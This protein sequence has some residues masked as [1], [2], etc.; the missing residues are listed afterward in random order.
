MSTPIADTSARAAGWAGAGAPGIEAPQAEGL[1]ERKKRLMRQQLSDTATRMFL[2]RGFDAVR[3]SEIAEACGVSEKTV[4]NYFPTKEALILDRLDATVAALRTG[5]ADPG[6]SPVEAALR[7]LD[8]EL[9][10]MTSWLAAQDDPVRAGASIRRF[11]AL[12]Q[13]APSLRA[14]QS[15][16]MDQFV[17][18]AAAALAGRAAM[19]PDDPEPRIAA[20]ALLGL[21]RVQFQAL[22]KYLD[23][24]RTPAQLHRAVSADVRR[25]ARLID[26]GLS[27]SAF[28]AG[29]GGQ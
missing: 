24:T 15:D 9:G 25:A 16:M 4:F 13:A 23:G 19:S 8:A 20:T 1:R 29:T 10:A 27:S 5:L 3:V 18:V 2:E 28:T 14:H 11:G 22:G 21:W 7:I 17:A 26:T 12:I 6:V